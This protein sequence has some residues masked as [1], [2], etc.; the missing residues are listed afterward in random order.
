M[1]T[2]LINKLKSAFSF[3]FKS[4]LNHNQEDAMYDEFEQSAQQ[5]THPNPQP[6][7]TPVHPHP[8][9]VRFVHTI[10]RY[11]LNNKTR[12]FLKSLGWGKIPP[13][14]CSP[15]VYQFIKRLQVQPLSKATKRQLLWATLGK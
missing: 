11:H 14:S 3:L 10:N 1:L 7:Y 8:R 15:H 12:R 9:F 13:R 6:I 4:K 2:K 5:P